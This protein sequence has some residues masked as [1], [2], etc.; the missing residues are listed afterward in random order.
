MFAKLYNTENITLIPPSSDPG[1]DNAIIAWTKQKETK[2][3][4]AVYISE[5]YTR[6]LIPEETMGGF[7]SQVMDDLRDTIRLPKSPASE[8]HVDALVRFIFAVATKVPLKTGL[9]EVLKNPKA[10]TPSLNMKSRF[11][12]EDAAKAS[13]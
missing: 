9:L 7:V 6:G 2:R 1:Y 5:L 13:R 3:G 12:L 8:E 11:K 4:F 10:E